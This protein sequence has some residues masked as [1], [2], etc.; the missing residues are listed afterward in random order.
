VDTQGWLLAA[1]VHTANIQDREGAQLVLAPLRGGFPRLAVI[2]ADAGYRGQ[3]VLW[4]A[5]HLQVRLEIVK[6]WW[7]GRSGVW[8]APGQAPPVKPSGFV[9]LPHRW[10]VERTFAWF[11]T[12]RRL[13][14]DFDALPTSS[15]ARLYLCM[16][17]LML[18]RLARAQS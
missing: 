5:E 12:N 18:R 2:W 6:H 16:I 7:T 8:V 14:V 3:C 4:V 10:I 15:E 9:P 13:V 11:L 17:R 1:C